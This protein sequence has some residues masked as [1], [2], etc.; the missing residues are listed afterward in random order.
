MMHGEN[1]ES[2]DRGWVWD[3]TQPLPFK[4]ITCSL[5]RLNLFLYSVHLKFYYP[6]KSIGN[7]SWCNKIKKC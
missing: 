1:S 6:S 3:L 4:I 5:T 7:K 2:G